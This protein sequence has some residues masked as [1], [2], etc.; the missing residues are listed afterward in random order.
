MVP[1]RRTFALLIDAAVR[2]GLPSFAFDA[3]D[4]MREVGVEVTLSTYNRLIRAAG[5]SYKP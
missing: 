4:A 1:N 5:L 2:A 3:F